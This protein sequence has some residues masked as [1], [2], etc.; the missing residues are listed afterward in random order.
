MEFRTSCPNDQDVQPSQS[1]VSESF[2]SETCVEQQL[3]SGDFRRSDS[4]ESREVLRRGLPLPCDVVKTYDDFQSNEGYISNNSDHILHAT[5]QSETSSSAHPSST[6]RNRSLPSCRIHL[7][8]SNNSQLVSSLS[9]SSHSYTTSKSL[10]SLS[11]C[12]S[13]NLERKQEKPPFSYISLILMAIHSSPSKRCTL[14]EIYAFLQRRFPFFRGS[15]QGWKNSV[16]HNLS[17]NDCFLKLP[18]G[19]GRPGKGHYWTVDP[20]TELKFE[21]GSLRRRALKKMDSPFSSK[22][23]DNSNSNNNGHVSVLLGFVN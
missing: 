20:T 16:R 23:N 8:E 2:E 22:P 7:E 11:P 19:V 6:L 18:K 21:Q 9:A 5:F 10:S 13:S 1:N 15:Y 14:N 3:L 4:F 17:L 12:S